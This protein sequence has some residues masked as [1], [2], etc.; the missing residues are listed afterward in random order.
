[1]KLC[2]LD[3]E[4]QP[5][6]IA[7]AKMVTLRTSLTT[8][9][10]FGTRQ[11]LEFA[12]KLL[13]RPAL[14]IAIGNSQGVDGVW[15]VGHNPVN[16]AVCGDYLEQSNQKRQLFEFDHDAVFKTVRRPVNILKMDVALLTA[17][18]H[19]TVVLEGRE[20]DHVQLGNQLQVVHAG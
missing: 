20:E 15:N 11:L 10:L 12:V 3:F 2:G 16:V 14:G 8:L 17:Q 5:S 19:Q 1:M 7:V 18:R 4:R 6:Q 9:T 13:N